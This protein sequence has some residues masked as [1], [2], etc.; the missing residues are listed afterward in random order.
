M[1][2]RKDCSF[3]YETPVKLHLVGKWTV[4]ETQL[5]NGNWLYYKENSYS[6]TPPK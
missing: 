3:Y 6:W 1:I 5:D 4:K 2:N